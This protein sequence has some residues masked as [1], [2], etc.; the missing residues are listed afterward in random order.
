MRDNT[1]K[2]T[3]YNVNDEKILEIEDDS[4]I[5]KDAQDLLDIVGS[6]SVRTII[7]RKENIT[8]EF[9]DLKTKVA[10]EILQKASNYGLKIGII[11]DFKSIK[12][13]SLRDFIYESNK[14][15]QVLFKE[16]KEEILKIFGKEL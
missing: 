12:S 11:G 2:T 14:T 9:F 15:K 3:I 10:G 8:P 6:Y 1:M 13:K 7:L 4:I 5:L 16:S